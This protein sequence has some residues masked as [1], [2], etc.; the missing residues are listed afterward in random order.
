LI[1]E[2]LE[3]KALKNTS[4]TLELKGSS[5]SHIQTKC[6]CQRINL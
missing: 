1:T 3:N 4:I 5:S 2:D 6:K